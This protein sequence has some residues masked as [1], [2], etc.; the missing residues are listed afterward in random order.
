MPVDAELIAI[1]KLCLEIDPKDRPR[2]AGVLAERVTS[3]L[4]SVESR[5]RQAEVERA[6]EAARAEEALQTA[7]QHEL[8][9]SAERRARKLQMGLAAVVLCVLTVGGIAATWTAAEFPRTA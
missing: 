9:A 3:Y 7:K 1:A 6:T 4:T 5:L 2:D 8:A